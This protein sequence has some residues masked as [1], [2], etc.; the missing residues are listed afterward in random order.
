MRYSYHGPKRKGRGRPKKYAGKIVTM[1]LDDEQFTVCAKCENGSR[2][3]YEA[4]V[5]IRS[6]KREVRVVIEHT[7]T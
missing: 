4:V 6:W 2:V 7:V 5:N 1:K 3:A